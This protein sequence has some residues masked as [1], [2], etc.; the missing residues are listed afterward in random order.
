ME[1]EHESRRSEMQATRKAELEAKL[2]QAVT[3]GKI[4]AAQKQL[5]LAKH[6][7]LQAEHAA[8]RDASREERAAERAELETWAKENG[9][10]LTQFFAERG[11]Q[12][13]ADGKHGRGMKMD[14]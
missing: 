13:N 3:D 7:E 14:R 6:A 12:G 10:D 11:P 4:T 9:I 5:I 1:T 2:T 8:D